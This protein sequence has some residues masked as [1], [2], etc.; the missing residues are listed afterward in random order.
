MASPSLKPVP[1]A[2]MV[3]HIYLHSTKWSALDYRDPYLQRTLTGMRGSQYFRLI[4][5]YCPLHVFRTTDSGG[6][7]DCVDEYRFARNHVTLTLLTTL[8][9][10]LVHSS[11]F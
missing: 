4:P 9:S 1:L 7:G 6:Y 5:G 10:S 2:V 3:S 11:K 8:L